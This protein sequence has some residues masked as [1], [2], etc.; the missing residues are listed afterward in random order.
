MGNESK[1]S[2]RVYEP[3]LDLHSEINHPIHG[4]IRIYSSKALPMTFLMRLDRITAHSRLYNLFQR[5]QDRESVCM[6]T[7][8]GFKL[9]R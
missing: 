4:P 7:L 1:P 5:I 8:Y 3:Q 6:L 9:E 2:M